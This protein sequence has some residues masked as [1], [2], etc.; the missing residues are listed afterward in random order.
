M[1]VVAK[2][3]NDLESS[4]L[5]EVEENKTKLIESFS[6]NL[7]SRALAALLALSSTSLAPFVALG[8]GVNSLGPLRPSPITSS[9]CI[10]SIC[11]NSDSIRLAVAFDSVSSS[12]SGAFGQSAY[13]GFS[14]DGIRTTPSLGG[15]M[16]NCRFS[17]SCGR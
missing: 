16:R 14:G 4:D 12:T 9:S 5:K 1:D 17:G 11:R 15:V 8:G 7:S 6:Q 10:S 2:M 3:F 13:S